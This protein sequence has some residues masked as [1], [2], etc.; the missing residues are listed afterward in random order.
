MPFDKRTALLS[1]PINRVFSGKMLASNLVLRPVPQPES[2]AME[3]S[4]AV[5][6]FS[7]LNALSVCS[8]TTPWRSQSDKS[9]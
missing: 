2:I 8:G 9:R 5:S 6:T 7:S 3:F 1:R 4:D